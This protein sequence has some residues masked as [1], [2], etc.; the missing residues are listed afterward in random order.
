MFF[1][2]CSE[3]SA[4]TGIYMNTYIYKYM[5][6]LHLKIYMYVYTEIWMVPVHFLPVGT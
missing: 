1:V 6:T 5:C 3:K 4:H 2:I